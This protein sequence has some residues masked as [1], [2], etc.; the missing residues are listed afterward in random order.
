[1]VRAGSVI[2][3]SVTRPQTAQADPPAQAEVPAGLKPD[4]TT[5]MLRAMGKLDQVIEQRLPA[6]LARAL[7]SATAQ[8]DDSLMCGRCAVRQA[9]FNRVNADAV[10]MAYLKAC[11]DLDVN[12]DDPGQQVDMTGHLPEELRP[13]PG[14]PIDD[15][16]F[17]TPFRAVTTIAGW[18]LCAFDVAADEALLARQQEAAAQAAEAQAATAAGLAPAEPV[19]AAPRPTILVPPPGMSAQAAARAVQQ[20]PPGALPGVP[21]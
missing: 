18:A 16:R 11:A 13:D 9:R 15:V 14:N 12:P 5:A 1:M 4:P 19:P 10:R 17:P 20:A 8:T 6:A 21:G 2:I 3:P 7:V